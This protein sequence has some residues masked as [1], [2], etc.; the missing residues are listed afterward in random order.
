LFNDAAHTIQQAKIQAQIDATMQSVQ[1]HVYASTDAAAEAITKNTNLRLLSSQYNIEIGVEFVRTSDMASGSV[2]VGNAVTQFDSGKVNPL[3][4]LTV[5]PDGDWVGYFHTH[6]NGSELFSH[7]DAVVSGTYGTPYLWT[8][9]GALK[10]ID[11]SAWRA[12]GSPYDPNP[13]ARIVK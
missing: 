5:H 1:G 8:P 3:I 9:S 13:Y 7:N 2:M 12:A 11:I 4:G 6:A 10:T